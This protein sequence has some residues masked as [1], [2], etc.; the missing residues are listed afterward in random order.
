MDKEDLVTSDS[1]FE[2]GT[3]LKPCRHCTPPV[4]QLRNRSPLKMQ[5]ET[6]KASTPRAKP[7]K[8]PKRN[9][10]PA[11]R[12]QQVSFYSSDDD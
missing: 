2:S 9:R 6:P 8:V 3:E 10:S 4:Y 1:D 5:K 7:T 11:K 12:K